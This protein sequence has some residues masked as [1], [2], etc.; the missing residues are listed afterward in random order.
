MLGNS[1]DFN[2]CQSFFGFAVFSGNFSS[3]YFFFFYFISPC[4]SFLVYL[5][6]SQSMW[7]RLDL[8]FLNN[9]FLKLNFSTI[10][11]S[12]HSLLV[13][14]ILTVFKGAIFFTY[15]NKLM[16]KVVICLVYISLFLIVRKYHLTQS[17]FILINGI[18]FKWPKR[19]L[20]MDTYFL[21]FVFL[22]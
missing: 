15:L 11:L 1:S 10:S 22:V 12:N 8:N 4:T 6:I 3:K 19:N 17:L 14:F 13:L 16:Q 20:L 7:R 2:D 18:I 5:Y 9:L 21:L